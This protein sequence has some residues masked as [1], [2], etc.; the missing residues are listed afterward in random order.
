MKGAGGE[1]D[2]FR[3]A[4]GSLSLHLLYFEA[5]ERLMLPDE[6]Q[7]RCSHQHATLHENGVQEAIRNKVKVIWVLG[8]A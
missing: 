4:A 2:C 5:E 6:L 8:L 1:G 7:Q 3:T